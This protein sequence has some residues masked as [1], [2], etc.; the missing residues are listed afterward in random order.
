MAAKQ[1]ISEVARLARPAK[2][3]E[4]FAHTRKLSQ[5]SKCAST[6][7]PFQRIR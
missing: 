5:G 7:K 6:E 1:K 2:D 4:K 3:P